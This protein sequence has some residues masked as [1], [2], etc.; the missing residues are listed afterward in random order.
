MA[1][2]DSIKEKKNNGLIY[3]KTLFIQGNS[4]LTNRN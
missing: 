2:R 1:K 4:D 3:N